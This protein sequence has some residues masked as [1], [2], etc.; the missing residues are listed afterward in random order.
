MRLQR[1]PL[2]HRTLSCNELL[3][4]GTARGPRGGPSPSCCPEE[5]TTPSLRSETL[6]PLGRESMCVLKRRPHA[7]AIIRNRIPVYLS[8]Q[9]LS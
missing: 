5:L 6:S 3:V 2:Q 9:S 7:R 8:S 4:P 1:S